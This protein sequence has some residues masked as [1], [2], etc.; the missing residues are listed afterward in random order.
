MFNNPLFPSS[1]SFSKTNTLA[2]SSAFLVDNVSRVIRSLFVFPLTC[3]FESL[4]DTLMK[5][6]AVCDLQLLPLNAGEKKYSR[7]LD[8]TI[9][10][11]QLNTDNW[12]FVLTIMESELRLLNKCG[13][14]SCLNKSVAVNELKTKRGYVRK[15]NTSKF[16]FNARK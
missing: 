9:P 1:H 15:T 10:R 3:I 16:N 7:I 13:N 4:V 2:I 8:R 5:P 6:L 12:A 14:W 11:G